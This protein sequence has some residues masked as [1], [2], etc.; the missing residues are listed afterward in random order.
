MIY[1]LLISV[2]LNSNGMRAKVGGGGSSLVWGSVTSAIRYLFSAAIA[3][4]FL[5][6]FVKTPFFSVAV[7]SIYYKS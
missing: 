7:S 2:R 1:I 3:Q 5:I 4:N 6:G